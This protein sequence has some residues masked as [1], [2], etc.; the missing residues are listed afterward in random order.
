MANY[1][2]EQMTNDQA[3][4]Y[5]PSSDELFFLTGSPAT[6]QVTYN[7][8]AGLNLASL[9]LTNG[10]VSH[11]FGA[12]A[13]AGEN[14]TFFGAS[15]ND[16]LAFGADSGADTVTLAG[17]TDAS[18]RY[19]GLGGNDVITGSNAND[20]IF[21]G[22]GNDTITGSSDHTATE[23]DYL[24]GGAGGDSITGGNGNDHI[25]GNS[26]TSVA[27]DADGA[28]HLI[29]G[30]GQ[31]YI[32]GNAGD[33]TIDGGIGNDRLYGGAGNDSIIGNDGNDYLQGNK[34]A[35]TLDCGNGNDT[36]HGG[37]DN[38]SVGGGAGN[39]WLY[40]DAG[41]DTVHGDAGYDT[42]QGGDGV[43]KFTFGATDANTANLSTLV[44]AAGHD[45][46]DVIWDFT[47]GTDHLALTGPTAPAAAAN[48]GTSTTNFANIDDAFAFAKT[49]LA[50]SLGTNVEVLQVGSD[51]ALFWSGTGNAVGASVDSVVLLHGVTASTIDFHDFV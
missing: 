39:D 40:G 1:L 46:V 17:V 48:V 10:T 5:N 28:D 24:N 33:D 12:N 14:L 51:T 2:F 6:V 19:Y 23:S 21:G 44:T 11:T 35:D 9:T 37:A 15:S 3:A 38:D 36:V 13:L 30:A 16:A 45:Q 43:D 22:L 8:A 7:A 27:G 18:S 42:V 50:T 34:G 41:N 25:Y 32:Q 20:V 29:G 4:A 49:A 47:H 31:D 26:Q